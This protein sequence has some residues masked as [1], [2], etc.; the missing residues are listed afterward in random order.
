MGKSNL[1]QWILSVAIASTIMWALLV[2]ST[3]PQAP[4]Q[5][6][7]DAYPTPSLSTATTTS[8][9]VSTTTPRTTH[10]PVT[11]GAGVPTAPAS[12]LPLSPT[13]HTTT[14][15]TPNGPSVSL[16]IQGL[17]TDRPVTITT[18]ESLLTLLQTLDTQDPQLHLKI[19]EYT[20]LGALI[21]SM[22]GLINGTNKQYWQYK[23]N[24]VEPQIGASGYI[25]K[26]G[27]QVDWYF[28]PSQQ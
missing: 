22:H 18:N 27:D 25:L 12:A 15:T 7:T 28:G 24:G 20:G 17:Y 16:S 21:T 14:T 1:W 11:R 4:I 8:K 23:I 19:Q 6:S 26:A 13:T 10:A 3:G 5:F 9:I 2:Y